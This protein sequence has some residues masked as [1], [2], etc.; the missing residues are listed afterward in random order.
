MAS[1]GQT[2]GIHTIYELCIKL[3]LTPTLSGA[4]YKGGG[5][6]ASWMSHIA[7]E[8]CTFYKVNKMA[9]SELGVCHT[10]REFPEGVCNVKTCREKSQRKISKTLVIFEE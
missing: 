1:R 6:P 10:P 4:R 2:K 7:Y 3:N 9:V 5:R 8:L